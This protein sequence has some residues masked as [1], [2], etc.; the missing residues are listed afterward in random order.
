MQKRVEE[1]EEVGRG[2]LEDVIFTW[3]LYESEECA[4]QK[5]EKG[6]F[7]NNSRREVGWRMQEV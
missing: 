2:F 6:N 7:G 4:M 3:D 1:L 5:E